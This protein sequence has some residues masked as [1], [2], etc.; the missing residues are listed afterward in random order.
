MK[1]GKRLS[2]GK[3]KKRKKKIAR[4]ATGCLIPA[5][6]PAFIVVI[7]LGTI[8]SA[9]DA[10]SDFFSDVASGVNDF[11]TPDWVKEID[12]NILNSTCIDVEDL[13]TILNMECSSYENEVITL[14]LGIKKRKDTYTEEDLRNLKIIKSDDVELGT[15]PTPVP[16]KSDDPNYEEKSGNQPKATATPKPKK[17]K[18]DK[19]ED[20]IPSA[21]AAP[22]A[23]ATPTK[24][25]EPNPQEAPKPTQD[26]NTSGGTSEAKYTYDRRAETYQYRL[27]WQF[28]YSVA[29]CMNM[30][31]FIEKKNTEPDMS[32][33]TDEE[34]KEMAKN[35][36][37]PQSDDE[38]TEYIVRTEDLEQIKKLFDT[39]YTSWGVDYYH[40][41][42]NGKSSYTYDELAA[43]PHTTR[44]D[45]DIFIPYTAYSS[46]QNY[47]YTYKYSYQTVNGNT[48]VKASQ[49]ISNKTDFLSKLEQLGI[50][51]KNMDLL[52]F[53]LN[54]TY[55]GTPIAEEIASVLGGKDGV[56]SETGD[57][58]TIDDGYEMDVPITDD[59]DSITLDGLEYPPGGLKVPLY[60]QNHNQPWSNMHYGDSNIAD[61]GCC[62]TSLAMILTYLKQETILPSDIVKWSG[63]RYYVKNRGSSW[64]MIGAVSQH[65][66]LSSKRIK[67][68]TDEFI[69]YLDKKLPILISVGPGEFTSGGHFMVIRGYTIENGK[70]YFL[71]ND[72]FYRNR[73]VQN[74]YRKFLASSIIS[75]MSG[76]GAWVIEK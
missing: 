48:V 47:L 18:K 6:I 54:K 2:E 30:E 9:V 38:E 26:I 17:D 41:Y 72:P 39:R 40:R 73:K 64:S 27:P 74:A 76:K 56:I 75:Q 57:T 68:S 71:I 1:G 20:E 37:T 8:G 29:V 3:K 24:S 13:R 53:V 44:A 46:V 12:E 65:W 28:V 45:G 21:G 5:I 19:K 16:K 51:K 23:G 62:P 25:P 36:T 11:F 34:L 67:I 10:L 60:Y 49:K 42:K 59:D 33:Y 58:S 63:D 70:K 31:N 52:Y 14:K 22:T 55:K 7:M 32:K 15:T 66:G 35:G 43:A 61:C 69:N 4:K 50:D